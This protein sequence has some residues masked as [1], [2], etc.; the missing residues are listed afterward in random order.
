MDV[1][2]KVLIRIQEITGGRDNVDVDMSELLKKEGFLASINDILEKLT[3][4][5]WITESRPKT[6]RITH[7]GVM[8]A[9]KIKN[10]TPDSASILD[11]Q[12]EKLQSEV[13]EFVILVEEF[14]GK[15]TADNFSRID[16]KLGEINSIA[17]KIKE[18]L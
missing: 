5:G 18:Q 14:N 6:A 1:Y 11:K 16:K 7:W 10:Q 8:A 4:E 15:A 3:T 2:Q 13:K 12:A 9:R 17:G